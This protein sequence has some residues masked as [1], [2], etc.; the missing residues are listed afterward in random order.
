[1][2]DPPFPPVCLLAAVAPPQHHFDED[3]GK[4]CR[5]DL[6]EGILHQVLGQ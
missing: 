2:P 4:L 1:M 6:N 3:Y 5:E